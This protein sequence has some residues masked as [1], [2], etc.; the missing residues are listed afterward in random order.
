[1]LAGQSVTEA[2]AAYNLPVETVKKWKQRA[3]AADAM[4]AAGTGDVPAKSA[5]RRE[6]IGELLVEYLAENLTTLR[7]Q[8][9]VFRDTAWL[10]QQTAGEAAILHGVLTDK[11]VRLLEALTPRQPDGA[12]PDA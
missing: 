4:D 3:R 2:A 1:M 11:A 12:A 8:Q 5:D 9:A 6:R 7:V 10:K